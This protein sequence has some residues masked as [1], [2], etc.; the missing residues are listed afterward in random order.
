MVSSSHG[1]FVVNLALQMPGLVHLVDFCAARDQTECDGGELRLKPCFETR[2]GWGC[3]RGEGLRGG[4]I[5]AGGR[6]RL[7]RSFVLEP[8]MSQ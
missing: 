4:D 6:G 3:G 5:G 2:G 7:S 1:C 8:L